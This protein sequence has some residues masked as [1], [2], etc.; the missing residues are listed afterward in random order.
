MA[1]VTEPQHPPHSPADSTSGGGAAAHLEE[2]GGEVGILVDEERSDPCVSMPIDCSFPSSFPSSYHAF[3]S[4]HTQECL[5]NLFRMPRVPS[6]RKNYLLYRSPDGSF[7]YTI[8]PHW[9][10]L[11]FT[12]VLVCVSSCLFI[13]NVCVPL[14]LGYVA[15]AVVYTIMTLLTLLRTACLD[16]G[17]ITR[18]VPVTQ[19]RRKYC[20]VCQLYTGPTAGHCEDCGV[21]IEGLDHHCPWT[22]HCIGRRNMSAFLTFNCTWLTYVV[23]VL[24]CLAIQS[25]VFG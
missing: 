10:G 21:C 23:F 17:F 6:A 14:G 18:S 2:G 9:T 4:P 7:Y 11:C 20:A 24:A 25:N 19:R 3:S 12:I 15:I 8:G 22:G 13:R 16:P 1:T 5:C